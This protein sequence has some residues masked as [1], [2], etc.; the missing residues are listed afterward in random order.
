MAGSTDCSS[1][2]FFRISLCISISQCVG[3]ALR[4]PSDQE[5]LAKESLNIYDSAPF[6][7]FLLCFLLFG[8]SLGRA[9]R[10]MELM[11]QVQAQL[12]QWGAQKRFVFLRQHCGSQIPWIS[13]LRSWWLSLKPIHWWRYCKCQQLLQQGERNWK[14]WKGKYGEIKDIWF[15]T[16]CIVSLPF[17]GRTCGIQ[18]GAWCR[19]AKLKHTSTLLGRHPAAQSDRLHQTYSIQ[20]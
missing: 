11:L 9:P 10:H 7:K 6:M 17:R 5:I 1:L 12:F 3:F 15:F 20:K 19:R 4:H 16:K 13:P 8:E 2:F 18:G 14:L